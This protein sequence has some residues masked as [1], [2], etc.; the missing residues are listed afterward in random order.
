[1]RVQRRCTEDHAWLQSALAQRGVKA[2]LPN[3]SV[4]DP[5][6]RK[7]ANEVTDWCEGEGFKL[8]ST[9]EHRYVPS[10]QV[11]GMKLKSMPTGVAL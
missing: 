3:I 2:Y 6:Q 8:W 1:M 10:M 5:K 9:S 7:P 11:G 4:T